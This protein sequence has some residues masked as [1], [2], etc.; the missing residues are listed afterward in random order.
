M[1]DTGGAMK[2]AEEIKEGEQ[3][4]NAMQNT[5]QKEKQKGK[6]QAHP[7]GL[8]PPEYKTQVRP[9]GPSITFRTRQHCPRY[10]MKN[11]EP[12]ELHPAE[13]SICHKPT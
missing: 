11:L 12:Q 7:H 2:I 5:K 4:Q 6:K 8:A 10:K 1:T 13:V 9:H 3:K